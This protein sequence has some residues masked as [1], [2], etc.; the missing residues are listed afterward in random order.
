MAKRT[1]FAAV[2]AK[3]ESVRGT[4]SAPSTTT[5]GV[6]VERPQIRINNQVV[7]TDEAS[8]SLDARSPIVG[9]AQVEISFPLYFKGSGTP[10]VAPEWGKIAKSMGLAEVVTLQTISATTIAL[11]NPTRITDSGNGLGALTV[12]TA[13]HLVT[14][15]GQKGEGIVTVAAAGQVDFAR[16]DAGP[17]FV[18]ES[19]GATFVIRYGVPAVAATAGSTTGFTAQSPWGNT[20]QQYRGMP[21]LLSGNPATPE[22]GVISDYSAARV[23]AITKTMGSALDTSTKVSIP[24]NVRYQPSSADE[25]STS[26]EVYRD[27]IRWRLR[28]CVAAGELEQQAGNLWR[29]N[30]RLM[31]LLESLGDASVPTPT[32]DA[33]RAGTWRSSRFA[34]DRAT[35][36]V[37][38]VT[39]AMGQRTGFPDN[40]NDPEGFD[41]PQITGRDIRVTANPQR[42]SVATRDLLS[43]VRSGTDVMIDAQLLGASARNPGQRGALTMP[44]VTLTGSDDGAQNDFMTE[45]IQGKPSEQDAGFMLSI[46]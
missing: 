27:G 37:S 45:D 38:R 5:D 19:A 41:P 1:R 9:G 17:A 29:L 6:L 35:I 10:G 40:P 34:I 46:W 22:Y 28:G 33:T 18:A 42:T 32:Y 13:F 20:A 3:T 36:G 4:F 11:A 23:A 39:V 7:D 43:K 2:T 26:V 31:G 24:A 16:L 21:V 25:P 14:P 15:T 8:G 44:A 30:V 12:G